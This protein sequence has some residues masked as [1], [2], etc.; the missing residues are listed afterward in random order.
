[1]RHLTIF[2]ALFFLAFNAHSQL[3]LGV[4]AGPNFSSISALEK[5]SDLKTDKS[6]QTSY[7][8]ALL[9][10]YKAMPELAIELGVQYSRQGTKWNDAE[11]NAIKLNYL[12]FPLTVSYPFI[13]GGGQMKIGTGGY[14]ASALSGVNSKA[15][16]EEE[17]VFDSSP[18]SMF[19]RP[20]LGIIFKTAYELAN[21]LSLAMDYQL[22][23][24]NIASEQL[25]DSFEFKNR[26]FS[27]SL[28]YYLKL[29]KS[30][31]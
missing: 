10:E 28:G 17:L 4:Q 21:G 23:L 9:A 27:I 14:Y 31:Q 13:L 15:G 1:M 11:Q 24:K 6:S 5:S 18:Y 2:S 30:K 16:Q 3:K 19:R 29:N 12:K 25:S 20:D 26:A 7:Q 8:T 22:G